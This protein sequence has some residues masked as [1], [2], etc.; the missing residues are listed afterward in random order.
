MGRALKWLA[1]NGWRLRMEPTGAWHAA[2][3]P[4]EWSAM[5]NGM[6]MASPPALWG[7]DAGLL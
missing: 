7:G 6:E 4:P 3:R 1:D 5:K 2:G